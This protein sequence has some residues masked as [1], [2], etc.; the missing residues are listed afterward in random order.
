MKSGTTRA[1]KEWPKK[2]GSQARSFASKVLHTLAPYDCI[3]CGENSTSHTN[4]CP[5][6]SLDLPLIKQ[7]CR[8]CGVETAQSFSP[9]LCGPCT[10]KKPV[11]HQCIAVMS[12]ASPADKLI[13]QFKFNA[14]FAA[15]VALGEIL[16]QEFKRHCECHGYPDAIVPIPLHQ[17][18][19]QERGF[20]QALELAKQLSFLTGTPV[21]NKTLTRI[22]NTLPQT[23]I[24]R[25]GLRKSNLKKAF[26]CIDLHNEAGVKHIALVDDVATTGATLGE[27]ARALF[28]GGAEKVDCFCIARANR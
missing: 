20:N 10:L 11:F 3:L 19:L 16:A 5:I 28:I 8:H 9:L 23:E 17:S 27:A 12:Y 24:K 1:F 21:L 15:G 14:N 13:R 6:C 4:L 18:R 2:A 22:K 26:A 25:A 7:P